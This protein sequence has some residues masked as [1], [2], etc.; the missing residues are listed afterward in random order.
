M[1]SISDV[2]ATGNLRM[3]QFRD[4]AAAAFTVTGGHQRDFYSDELF[5]LLFYAFYGTRD[6]QTA[7]PGYTERAVYNDAD[8][9]KTGRSNILTTVNGSV[10]AQTGIGEIDEDLAAGWKDE[11]RGRAIANR[12]LFVENFYGDKWEFDDGCAFDGRTTARKTAWVHPDPRKFTSV[13]ADVLTNYIDLNVDLV[14]VA[15]TAWV[16]A[17]GRG[18]VPLSSAGADAT[19]YYCDQFYSYLANRELNY[20][21]S[22][23]AGGSLTIGSLAGLAARISYYSLAHTDALYGSRLMFKPNL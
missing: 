2:V 9:R 19:K 23:R 18:F 4:A 3:D 5:M 13:D 20:L 1:Y 22:V 21:R 12:F 14:S 17:V 6:S 7:L 11:G 10:D 8:F 16:G 15:T